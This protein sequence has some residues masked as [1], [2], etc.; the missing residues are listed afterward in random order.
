[1]GLR[2]DPST[3]AL[4]RGAVD[5]ERPEGKIHRIQVILEEE[6]AGKAGRV[7]EGIV[8]RAVR[9]LR[10]DEKP[11]PS[12]H[13]RV[14]R[15]SGREEAEEGPRSLAGDALA[16]AGEGGVRIAQQGLPPA[17]VRIL[18][19]LEPSDGAPDVRGVQILADGLEPAQHRPGPV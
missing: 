3:A 12:R 4:Q 19:T 5:A 2:L 1:M 14:L 8:P 7:P 15:L 9:S 16:F 6:D 11:D 17:A 18:A 13:R 10:L